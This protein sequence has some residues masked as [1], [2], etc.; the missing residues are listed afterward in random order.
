MVLSSRRINVRDVLLRQQADCGGSKRGWFLRR[1]GR[2]SGRWRRVGGVSMP[3]G[4]QR[5]ATTTAT[6]AEEES[7]AVVADHPSSFPYTPGEHP[8]PRAHHLRT[9][10]CRASKAQPLSSSS[11]QAQGTVFFVGC[12]F[13]SGSM[14]IVFCLLF[15]LILGNVR[16]VGKFIKSLTF[17]FSVSYGSCVVL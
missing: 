7:T 6:V 3:R 9:R 14:K 16:K 17:S 4:T 2:D 8:H 12:S 10:R 13:V 11:H 1:G 5:P 15:S